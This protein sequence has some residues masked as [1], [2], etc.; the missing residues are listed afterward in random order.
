MNNVF[1]PCPFCGSKSV[2]TVTNSKVC[3][4]NGLGQRVW[5]TR[6]YV[7]C[8]KC[9]ARGSIASG[10]VIPLREHLCFPCGDESN[11][12]E[13]QTTDKELRIKAIELWNRRNE[14]DG[15]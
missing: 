12:P 10:K 5:Q 4:E 7:R 8:N 15:E 6:W 13:W 9:S 1:K 11:L 14:G 2:S 3:G